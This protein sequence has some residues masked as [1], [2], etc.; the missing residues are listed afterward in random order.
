MPWR[1]CC[2]AED[3]TTRGRVG[4]TRPECWPGSL[5]RPA[6]AGPSRGRGNAV[7]GTEAHSAAADRSCL[8]PASNQAK[9]GWEFDRWN[10]RQFAVCRG[11]GSAFGFVRQSRGTWRP[12]MPR[13]ES[14]ER[15]WG[16]L[17][18]AENVPPVGPADSRPSS[19][20]RRPFLRLPGHW[21]QLWGPVEAGQRRE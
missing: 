1:S 10:W 4:G 5:C 8:R 21:T 14:P 7:C 12:P 3:A 17:P 15:G 13:S 16:R 19:D 11:E 9:I 6:S 2:P 18:S 20:G